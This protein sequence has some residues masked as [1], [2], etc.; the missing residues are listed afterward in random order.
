MGFLS[1]L[2]RPTAG[3][4]VTSRRASIVP[5]LPQAATQAGDGGRLIT[6]SS[7]LDEY[8]R[9]GGEGAAGVAV[10]PDTSMRVAAVFGCIRIIAGAVA[11]MP[12]D[13]K[14]RVDDKT[15][16]DASDHPLYEVIT[17]RPNAWMTPSGFRRMMQ[18][19]VL[20]RGNAY[21][22][23]VRGVGGRVTGLLPLHPDRVRVEQLADLSVVYR[24]RRKDGAEIVFGQRDVFHLIGLTL[25]GVT[26]L[27]VIGYAR[28]TIGLAIAMGTHAGS[29]FRNG[30]HPGSVI[31]AKGTLGME[32]IENLK[33]SLEIYRGAE[34]SGKALILEEDMSFDQIGMSS[35]DAQFVETIGATRTDIAMF[36]GVPPHMLG[37]TAKSTSWGSGIEQQSIGFVA[38]TL[39]DWLTGWEQTIAR[40]LITEPDIF[41]RFNRAGLVRGDIKT[42]ADAY[43]KFRQMRVLSAND[44]RE[45][46][47]WN[48]VPGGD[49]YDNPLITTDAAGG[50]APDDEDKRNEPPPTP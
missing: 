49:E 40:D 50:D 7:E 29:M 2:R 45:L 13:L 4:P 15:R 42:R 30:A 10:T 12:L 11:T 47:D 19:H 27:S 37:D 41:A 21:A 34:N 17:R 9:A 14:R 28:E 31:T 46:E 6:T 3:E 32:G 8:L 23:I 33:T 16:K 38:Y 36:F 24:Y 20:L 35:V 44:V 43:M 5:S 48:P 26:G 18:A 1:F 39:E 22:L 25:D